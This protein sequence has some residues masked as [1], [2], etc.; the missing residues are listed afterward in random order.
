MEKDGH[1]KDEWLIE[2]MQMICVYWIF[3]LAHKKN[4][5]VRVTIRVMIYLNLV[6]TDPIYSSMT[7][8][9]EFVEVNLY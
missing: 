3:F 9:G 7:D 8:L 4:V 1:T 5:K 6:S 2:F